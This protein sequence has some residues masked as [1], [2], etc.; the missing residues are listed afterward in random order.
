V[1]YRI[2]GRTGLRVSALALG[3]VE[4]G[5]DYGIAA[6]GE[7]GRPPESEAIRLVHAALDAGITLIDTARAY[8]ES[9]AVLGQALRGRRDQVVLATKTRTQAEDGA[10]L[11][12]LELRR[13]MRQSLETSLRLLQT[14]YVDIW[15]VHNVDAEL[16]ERRDV[17]AEVFD[18][19]RRSGKARAV[20][21]STYGVEMP[22]AAIGSGLFDMLQVA[23][24]VLDQRL[25]D[26]VFAAAAEKNVGILVRSILL[27]GALTV[28]G[29]YLPDRLAALRARSRAFRE[30]VIA[31]SLDASP[32]QAA[33]AF[34]LAHPHIHSVL[35]GLRSEWEL[36][37]ALGAVD[38]RL[39]ADL[40]DRLRRLRLDDAEL[41]NP[42]TW[43][44]P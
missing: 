12:A 3:T 8:G 14:D 27:K 7:Y 35:V 25:A 31:S 20:G 42:A 43:D 38:V 34:G 36:R 29:D 32:V 41:L 15:Q 44:I 18:W 5:L 2:L 24:S 9:E 11:D 6:P 33:I 21:G 37:E 1:D 4:L 28:R 30:L 17:V 16:L 13:M 26:Q 40:L 39:P 19:A 10:T 22:L 23:Y